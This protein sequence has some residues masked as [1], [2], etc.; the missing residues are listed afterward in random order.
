[1]S[2]RL[3]NALYALGF[4]AMMAFFLASAGFVKPSDALSWVTTTT[5]NPGASH[6][7]VTICHH[8]EGKGETGFGYNIITVNFNSI[9]DAQ[10]VGGHGDHELD[11]IPPYTYTDSQGTVNYPGKGDQSV[12]ENGCKPPGETT[13][14]TT[15]GT[16]TTTT[17]TTTGTTTTETTTTGTTTTTPQPP[18]PNGEP[19]IHG[20]DGQPGNDACN[21]CLP[22]VNVQKCPP[23]NDST[24]ITTTTTPPPSTTTE[25]QTQ[26]TETQTTETTPPTTKPPATKPPATKPPRQLPPPPKKHH[27]PKP[28]P[29]CP[30]GQPFN[31]VCGVQGSG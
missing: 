27:K 15:T 9:A 18:C 17:T 7:K 23:P 3:K 20:Q 28:P 25:T 11:I 21:P 26:T 29:A 16:T 1:M 13:T 5:D 8:V 4:L 24:T 22:P 14:T 2:N 31:G 10:S 12:L 19:P 30:P 6:E